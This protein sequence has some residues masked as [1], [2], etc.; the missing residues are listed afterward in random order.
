MDS[1]LS[2]EARKVLVGELEKVIQALGVGEGRGEPTDK[3]E[4]KESSCR[5]YSNGRSSL[6]R[7]RGRLETSQPQAVAGLQSPT[8]RN[9]KQPI[10]PLNPLLSDPIRTPHPIVEEP[11]MTDLGNAHDGGR[12]TPN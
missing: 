5:E 6:C 9:R 4:V 3:D 1:I 12:W 7:A 2:N 8:S 11:P 10:G